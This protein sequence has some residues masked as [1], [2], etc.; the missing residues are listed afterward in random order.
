MTRCLY[1]LLLIV[2]LSA[3]SQGCGIDTADISTQTPP[4][5]VRV[6]GT[7]PHDSTENLF[8]SRGLPLIVNFNRQFA[9][10]EVSH[11]E[12]VPRP[13]S[14]GTIQNPGSDARQI[15]LGDVILDPAYS[16]YRLV[17]DGP[18]MPAPIV[19]SYYSSE[20]SAIEGAMHGHVM[21]SRGRTKPENV[22]VYALVPAGRE[23]EF[24]LTGAE[25]IILGR[26]VLGVTSTIL[27]NGVEGGWFRLAGLEK[28]R[29]YMVIAILDTSGD[30]VYEL[31]TDWW[32]YYRDELDFPQEVRAGVSLGE[33]FTPPLP[34]M[35]ADIDFWLLPP[36]SLDPQFE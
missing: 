2:V 10:G 8:D 7:A 17:L 31:D 21:I 25:E 24:A 12:L 16:A 28:W 23:D 3:F 1:P 32:G 18:A 34:G 27:I 11:L 33:L 20:H 9:P 35:R 22:L 26:P 5:I 30:G 15:V 36:G 19:L 6:E 13:L 29:S 4:L 14:M